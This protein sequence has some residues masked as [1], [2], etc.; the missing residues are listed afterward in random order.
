MLCLQQSLLDMGQLVKP[1]RR[2]QPWTSPSSEPAT[3]AAPSPRHSSEPVTPSRSR[4]AIRRM[5]DASLPRPAPRVAGSNAEAVAGGRRSSSWRSRSRSASDDR[6]RDRRRG[7]P[8][9]SSSTSRTGCLRRRRPAIDT[10]TSNAEELADAAARRARRQGIQH[11]LRLAPERPD[12]GRRPARRLRRADDDAGAKR[13]RPRARRLDRPRPVD[14]GPLARARQLEGLAFLN[15][16]LNIANGGSWQSGWK[17]V[18]APAS[19]PVAA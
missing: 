15:I 17:L 12:R 1:H 8:A 10:D 9:R 14:V 4:R 16:T 19:L 3:S 11:A 6:R 7:S 5:P 18:G 13:D 2:I